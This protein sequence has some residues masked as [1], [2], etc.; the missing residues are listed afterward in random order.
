MASDE[1]GDEISSPESGPCA[2]KRQHAPAHGR[3]ASREEWRL[4]A[5]GEL[6]SGGVSSDV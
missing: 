6:F 5:R 2:H 3:Q 1:P 4:A